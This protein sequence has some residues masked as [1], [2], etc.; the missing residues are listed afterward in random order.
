MK[1][2]NV[3]GYA[4]HRLGDDYQSR[5]EVEVIDVDT[6]LSATDNI[7]RVIYA[8]DPRTNLP[9]GDLNY[10]VSDSVSSEIKE[11]I[12]ANLFM[13]V[14]SAKNIHA[15]NGLSDEDI[16]ALSRQPNESVEEYASR[17]NNSIQRDKWLIEQSRVSARSK[18]SSVP[19]E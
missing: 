18:N 6:K 1:K 17:L 4:F 2:I 12:K 10:W 19:V 7:L 15:A 5:N 14:S 9:T 8:P 3:S 13:D 11:F 16:L